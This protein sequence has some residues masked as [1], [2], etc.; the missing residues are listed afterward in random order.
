MAEATPGM[1]RWDEQW[2]RVQRYLE[3]LQGY[4]VPHDVDGHR[5][6]DDAYAFFQNCHHLKDWL[7]NDPESGLTGQEVEAVVS[8]S[9]DLKL[10]ADVA[11]GTKHL[12]LN[13]KSRT[14][15]SSTSIVGDVN[16]ITGEGVTHHFRIVVGGS[17]LNAAKVAR[18]AVKE[19]EMVLRQR[20]KLP[21]PPPG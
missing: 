1:S 6:L 16:I 21:C 11:N 5:V 10:C 8:G 20:G 13:R 4:M 14:G 18:N 9:P 15:H 12:S 7:K 3:R 19:W 2:E 17:D